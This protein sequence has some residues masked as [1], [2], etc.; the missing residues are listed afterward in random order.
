VAALL[1]YAPGDV[2]AWDYGR[3]PGWDEYTQGP[4]GNP[5]MVVD[6]STQ[7]WWPAQ[8]RLRG[9]GFTGR[10]GQNVTLDPLARRA[11]PRFPEY[12]RLFLLALEDGKTK[13]A[14]DF[15]FE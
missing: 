8:N 9:G 10:W 6:R 1:G 14:F 11:G 7:D 12:W 2:E 5:A 13:K 4:I 15:P 3:V